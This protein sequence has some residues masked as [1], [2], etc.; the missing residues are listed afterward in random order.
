VKTGLEYSSWVS[1]VVWY[2][3]IS[4][5]NFFLSTGP[6][7]GHLGAWYVHISYHSLKCFFFRCVENANID[8]LPSFT[9]V[10]HPLLLSS[11]EILHCLFWRFWRIFSLIDPIRSRNRLIC[12][13][14]LWMFVSLFYLIS[15]R[16]S[17]WLLICLFYF[18]VVHSFANIDSLSI[19][20]R[21]SFILF[22]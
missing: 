7:L 8:S 20:S 17:G 9:F 2:S 18:F 11:N 21:S 10:F 19:T 15:Q 1:L 13:Y 5:W 6:F 16:F 4:F 22:F 3:I 14:L 12:L